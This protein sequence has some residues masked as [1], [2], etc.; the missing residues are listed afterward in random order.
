MSKTAA[1]RQ[2]ESRQRKRDTSAPK[3]VTCVTKPERDVTRNA[4]LFDY[5]ANRQDYATRAEPE[6]LNWGP[7]MSAD[8][9]ARA[10]LSA[11]RVTIPGDWDYVAAGGA[12]T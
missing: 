9:L 1:Q 7:W 12:W 11:N 5:E 4:C 3:T 8:E 2:R 6:R 10:G